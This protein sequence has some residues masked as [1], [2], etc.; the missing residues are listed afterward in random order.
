MLTCG[1]L[2]DEVIVTAGCQKSC[3]HG[4]KGP[5]WKRIGNIFEEKFS[6]TG[7]H[8]ILKDNGH[9]GEKKGL[10]TDLYAVK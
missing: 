1:K 9:F 7:W 4:P 2:C 5:K 3:A 8:V 10:Q 6:E